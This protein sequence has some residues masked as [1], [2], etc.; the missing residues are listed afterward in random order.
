MKTRRQRKGGTRRGGIRNLFNAAVGN[1]KNGGGRILQW[2]QIVNS[3]S[4]EGFRMFKGMTVMMGGEDINDD[5]YK[6]LNVK[7]KLDYMQT[8]AAK[9]GSRGSA[10]QQVTAAAIKPADADKS[11]NNG[12]TPEDN[13]GTPE[14]NAGT[15]EDNAGTPENN[16]GTPE[17][18]AGTPE[19]NDGTPENNAGTPENNN[20]S[21]EGGTRKNYRNRI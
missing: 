6:S 1:I 8:V 5:K 4:D 14:D 9:R 12:N 19:N 3:M 10:T 17:N 11:D 20:K 13:A 18:N 2:N 15:P 16:A 21:I 7:P